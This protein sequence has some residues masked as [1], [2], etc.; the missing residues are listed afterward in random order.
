MMSENKEIIEKLYRA[1]LYGFPLLVLDVHIQAL[2]NTVHPTATK[3]PVNQF[4]HAKSVAGA[5][6]REIIHPNIDTVY[7][8]AHIDLRDGPLWLHKPHA[9][10]YTSAEVLDAYGNAVAIVGSEG[11]GGN[12][13]TSVIL[14]TAW[15]KTPL[16]EGLPVIRIHT[17]LCW[18]LARILKGENDAAEI[19]NVQQGFDLRPLEQVGKHYAYPPGQWIPERDFIPYDK[20]QQLDIEI[21]L[22]RINQLLVDN[23]G[24]NPDTELLTAVKP[25]GVGP[26][27]RFILSAL[28][29]QVQEAVK[30]FFVRALED[31]RTE[32]RSG[33]N[34]VWHGQWRGTFQNSKLARFG[35]AYLFRAKTAWWGFGA[36]PDN[37]A[38]YPQTDIDDQGQPLDGSFS[39]TCHFHTLPPVQEFWSLTAY[40]EDGFLIP[41]T[42]GRNGL[43]D[44]SAFV[45]NEDGSLDIHISASPPETANI[46]NW[47]PVAEGRF[48]LVLRLY[49]PD[50]RVRTGKWKLPVISRLES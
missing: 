48:G 16:P 43:N 12:S 6:D 46:S 37:I 14:A 40:G 18:I 25:Y 49:S 27:E 35:R 41:N 1:Y 17:R 34:Y 3:A 7:S 42:L 29:S 33:G 11:I 10:R 20:L 45:L 24:D 36:L 44:R 22:N 13:D 23:P 9:D 30:G 50:D 47:L 15:D 4:I 39:Y 8:K 2:T 21:S 32:N 26:G 38:I 28:P 31:F 19:R 5:G